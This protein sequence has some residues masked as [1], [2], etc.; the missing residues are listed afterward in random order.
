MRPE[1]DWG[2]YLVTDRELAG[3]RDLKEI[4][5]AA[6]EGGVSV[7]QLREKDCDTRSFIGLAGELHALLRPRRVPLLINDRVD[8]ALAVGAE[9]VHVGQSDMP[10]RTARRLM[11]P[12]ALIGVSVETPSQAEEL[13]GCDVDY[14]GVSPIFATPTKTDTGSP[15]G[16]EGLRALRARSRHALV[17]IGGISAANAAEVMAAGANGVAV[18]SAICAAPEPREAAR[19]IR[20]EVSG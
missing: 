1:V 3:G 18:V 7:V 4:V 12:D 17:A 8:V 15:W 6:V 2:V 13:D 10:W 5:S 16:V 14:L 9:G 20:A 11:G 19:T